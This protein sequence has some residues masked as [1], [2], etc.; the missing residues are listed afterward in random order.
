MNKLTMA[1]ISALALTLAGFSFGQAAGTSSGATTPGMNAPSTTTQEEQSGQSP[2]ATT[3]SQERRAA[4]PIRPSAGQLRQI[5]QLKSAGLYEGPIDGRMGPQT[6]QAISKY[7]Q[8]GGLQ[9]TGTLHE[10][11]LSAL[12][13]ST[14]GTGQNVAPGTGAPNSGGTDSETKAPN[15]RQP[16]M[17]GNQPAAPNKY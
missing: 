16:G 3:T 6:T 12:H 8:Q 14:T 1:G 10:Q 5:Q 4:A 11:T 15:V 13:G 2:S 17:S 9:P 7:Q